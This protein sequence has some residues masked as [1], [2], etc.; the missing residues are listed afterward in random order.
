MFASDKEMDSKQK[1]N[2]KVD[3]EATNQYTVVTL[4]T[5]DP[6]VDEVHIKLPEKST[7]DQEQTA[8]LKQK[9]TTFQYDENNQLLKIKWSGDS[10]ESKR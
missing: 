2:I 1:L 9:S 10:S 6:I 4:L 3:P 7:Y 8:Q 5:E